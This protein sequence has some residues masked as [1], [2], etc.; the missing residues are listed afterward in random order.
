MKL[1]VLML[2][3]LEL[4]ASATV[5][6]PHDTDMNPTRLSV[7]HMHEDE[8]H[9]EDEDLDHD[10]D[11]GDD[12]AHEINPDSIANDHVHVCCATASVTGI[13]HNECECDLLGGTVVVKLPIGQDVCPTG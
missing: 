3:G 10:Y 6:A 9:D 8:D 12:H 4:V 1:T 2:I 5:I 13:T 11:H 7:S